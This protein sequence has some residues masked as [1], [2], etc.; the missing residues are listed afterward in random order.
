MFGFSSLKP[1]REASCFLFFFFLIEV[2]LI[3][4]FVLV[5][6]VQ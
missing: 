6:Y 1:V 3:Y 5:S 4:Y 2:Q